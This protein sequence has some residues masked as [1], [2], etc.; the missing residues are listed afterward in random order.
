[1]KVIVI[2]AGAAGMMAAVAA[3]QNGADVIVLEKNEKCGKKI[4]ITG[5]GRCNVTNATTGEEFL[6]NIPRNPRFLM[7]A[8]S[9]FDSNDLQDM[10]KNA[11]LELKTE[12]GQRV[13]PQSDRASDVTKAFQFMMKKHGVKLLLNTKVKRILQTDGMVTGVESDK[14]TFDCDSV[15][16]ATGGISYPSTGSTGDGFAFAK[17]TGHRVTELYPSLIPILTKEK[18]PADI[19]GL[20]L[21]NVTLY[22][23]NGK[24]VIFSELGEM[25]FTHFGISG[26]LVLSLSSVIAGM[27]ISKISVYIDLK[28]ALD[29]E[30]L[31]KRI[32]RDFEKYQNKQIVNSLRDLL[33]HNM[34]PVILNAAGIDPEKFVNQISKQERIAL[35]SALKALPITPVGFRP[36][37]EAVV[38]RGGVN[39]GDINPRTME[40]KKINGLYFAGEVI[41]VDGFTG[42]FN[43][44]IAFTTGYAAGCASAGAV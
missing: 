11:G 36:I 30:T 20:T 5:K 13:F 28:P 44:Q 34:I 9:R 15:I 39:I 26:P 17:D 25:L 16:I 27:D 29:Q 32:L 33:P 22:A 4:Y 19:S 6:R 18:W 12:R 1:M 8:L 21:K 42:G 43:L 35:L 38:T 2:G 10:L 37:E 24:K 31:D 40:S 7:S 3:A 14:G 41:D 23:K